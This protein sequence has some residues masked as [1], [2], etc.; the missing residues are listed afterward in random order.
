MWKDY[1]T[2]PYVEGLKAPLITS[3]AVITHDILNYLYVDTTIVKCCDDAA[4]LRNI[5]YANAT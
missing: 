5:C 4:M 3:M 1:E 2:C